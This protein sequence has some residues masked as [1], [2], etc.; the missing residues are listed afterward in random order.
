M[1]IVCISLFPSQESR[2][3]TQIIITIVAAH[4][5]LKH[6]PCNIIGQTRGKGLLNKDPN[7]T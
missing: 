3:F 5:T 7:M 6:T 2:V 4:V 1:L